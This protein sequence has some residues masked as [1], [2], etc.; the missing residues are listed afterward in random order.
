MTRC[1]SCRRPLCDAC[2]RFRI[3]E[4]SACAR[5]AYEAGTRS[6][7]RISLAVSFL[8]FAWASEFWVARHFDLWH[9][10]PFYLV[11]AAIVVAVAAGF[12]AASA[13]DLSKSVVE[14][15][16]RSEGE[17]VE[18]TTDTG[19]PYRAGARRVLLAA[20][21]RL[22]GR[23]TALAVGAS[24]LASAVL[25]PASLKLPRWIET[26]IVLAL[27][28]LIVA[29][30]LVV[31]LYRGFRLRDD[32]VYFAP[33][34][35]PS[36]DESGDAK[37]SGA[38]RTSRGGFGSLDGLDGCGS[39]DGEGL[40]VVIA[41]ALFLGAALGAAW[42]FVELA[43]PVIFFLMYWLLMRAIGRVANDR[44]ACERHPARALGW[45]ALWATI[46]V[47]PIALTTWALHALHR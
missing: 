33:W 1:A 10:E 19:N 39:M 3:N 26:E 24:M 36:A 13:R 30:T 20:S 22:S 4:R 17:V 14:N 44:H 16:E 12:I 45:G 31:L 32:H 2:F 27:W 8:S 18:W 15:R 23:A 40:V 38:E 46:Y 11:A 41:L 43:L 25:L 34:D 21:P 35:R 29:S 28:W 37:S 42:I 9:E 7:R 5:C 47:V 6:H